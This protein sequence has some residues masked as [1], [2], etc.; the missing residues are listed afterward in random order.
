MG[1]VGSGSRQRQAGSAGSGQ[2]SAGGG[3]RQRAAQTARGAVHRRAWPGLPSAQ[4]PTRKP[5]CVPATPAERRRHLPAPLLP[6]LLPQLPLPPLF[7]PPCTLQYTLTFVLIRRQGQPGHVQ[8]C[9]QPPRLSLLWLLPRRAGEVWGGNVLWAGRTSLL[10]ASLLWLL[11]R[12]TGALGLGHDSVNWLQLRRKAGRRA[13][14]QALRARPPPPAP[15]CPSAAHLL[16]LPL[17]SPATATQPNVFYVFKLLQNDNSSSHLV[18]MVDLINHSDDPNAARSGERRGSPRA[19]PAAPTG[20]R[21]WGCWQAPR[22]SARLPARL[23]ACP[24]A[25]SPVKHAS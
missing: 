20:S 3:Q 21:S 19:P 1:S 12:W 22:W 23:P 25:S 14:R 16:P 8:V 9:V 18:P 13:G 5:A 4:L 7:P 15:T 6:P 17:R 10:Y 11:P 24:S 2:R